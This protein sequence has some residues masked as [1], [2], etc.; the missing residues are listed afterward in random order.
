MTI[1]QIL[2]LV[3]TVCYY[4]IAAFFL[5]AIIRSFVKT[6]NPQEA[7]LYTVIMIPFVLRIL[8]LK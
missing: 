6:K 3:I 7:I 1:L 8:R 5:V 2:N 4:L